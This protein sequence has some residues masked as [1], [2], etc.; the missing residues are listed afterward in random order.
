MGP[1]VSP[2]ANVFR[3]S[4]SERQ[5]SAIASS[6]DDFPAPVG[7]VIK[8]TPAAINGASTNRITDAMTT[9]ATTPCLKFVLIV[10]CIR[11]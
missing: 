11:R 10:F 8:N 5:A 4:G 1:L 9:M 2:P 6:K 7:P 3:A